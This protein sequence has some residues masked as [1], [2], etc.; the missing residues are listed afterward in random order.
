MGQRGII[1]NT[2]QRKALPADPIAQAGAGRGADL[3]LGQV[4]P[5]VVALPQETQAGQ[6]AQSSQSNNRQSPRSTEQLGNARVFHAAQLPCPPVPVL[7]PREP[8]PPRAGLT[9]PHMGCPSLARW[10]HL[11]HNSIQPSPPGLRGGPRTAEPGQPSAPHRCWL[12]G[13]CSKHTTCFKAEQPARLGHPPKPH[14][15]IPTALKIRYQ[16]SYEAGNKTQIWI[17][18]DFCCHF[19]LLGNQSKAFEAPSQSHLPPGSN[20]T[21]LACL[22]QLASTL[23]AAHSQRAA[24]WVATAPQPTHQHPDKPPAPQQTCWYPG[25]TLV[26]PWFSQL[27]AMSQGRLM[28]KAPVVGGIAG[29]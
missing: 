6:R 23:L 14:Y 24:G 3:S 12:E 1:T 25:S 13:V 29:N 18:S 16:D 7:H 27:G 26:W 2:E 10:F 21:R 8:P 17:T 19:E 11:T 4:S 15:N 28:G 9:Q 20:T 22:H 5:F